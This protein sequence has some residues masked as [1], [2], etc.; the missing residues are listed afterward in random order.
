MSDAYD[1]TVALGRSFANPA[2]AAAWLN[3]PS[4]ALK[5]ERPVVVAHRGEYDAVIAAI[6][7]DRESAEKEIV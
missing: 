3:T 1:F 6:S 4:P 7:A 5:G 2:A